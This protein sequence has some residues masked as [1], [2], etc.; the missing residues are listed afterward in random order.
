MKPTRF[1]DS[2][3]RRIYSL[4]GRK[5]FAVRVHAFRVPA[6]REF[7]R[8]APKSLHELTSDTAELDQKS[9]KSLLFSL[10][11]RNGISEA[12]R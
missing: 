1:L 2:L 12:P 6:D 4:F 5:K 8:N 11:S 7:A 3:L 10:L 9:E